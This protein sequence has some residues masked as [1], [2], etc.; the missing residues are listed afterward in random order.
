MRIAIVGGGEVGTAYAEAAAGDHSVT[1]CTPRPGRGLAERSR[2]AGFTVETAPGPWLAAAER[3]WLCVPG[4]ISAAVCAEVVRH[5]GPGAV[6]VDLTSSAAEDKRRSA[7]LTEAA[8][9]A[10]VDAVIM[11]PVS[12]MGA[13]APVVAAGPGAETAI[14]DLAALGAPVTVL[15]HSSIGDAAILKLLRTVLSKGLEA[16]A[17][18]CLV[19]AEQAGVRTALYD[20]LGDI[21][22]TGFTGFLD[23]LVTSHVRHSPRRQLEV[24]RAA[25]QLRALGLSTTMTSAAGEVFSRSACRRAAA[26]PPTAAGLEPPAALSWLREAHRPREAGPTEAGPAAR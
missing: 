6:V 25:D 16:L 8:G 19:A 5:L 11:G 14:A 15:P 24:E 4:D 26:P 21:D 22:A 13:R 2:Q 9:S 17:V 10:Y 7:A 1:V 12:T 20:A 23:L 18:E 3:V